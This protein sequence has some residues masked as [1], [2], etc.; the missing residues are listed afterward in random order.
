MI[1]GVG[2]DHQE[3]A[4]RFNSNNTMKDSKLS[5][6]PIEPR[7][8]IEAFFLSLFI[9][10]SISYA[11][12]FV[13]K[14]LPVCRKEMKRI[15]QLGIIF[16]NVTN[17]CSVVYHGESYSISFNGN[18]IDNNN[19]NEGSLSKNFDNRKHLKKI[20]YYLLFLMCW[21][22]FTTFGFFPSIQVSYIHVFLITYQY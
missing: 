22:C 10:I 21:N 18:N 4:D 12:F 9:T 2:E 19:I 17:D 1:Q 7:F 3:C 16:K 8:S 5:M 14:Y 15:K 11:G 13:L 6:K 20:Y